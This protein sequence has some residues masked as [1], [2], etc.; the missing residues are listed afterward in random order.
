MERV[1]ITWSIG[2]T[3]GGDD[4]GYGAAAAQ[5]D[6]DYDF[7]IECDAALDPGAHD[8]ERV[9]LTPMRIAYDTGRPPEW[10]QWE[11]CW[12]DDDSTIYDM[13]ADAEIEIIGIMK[14]IAHPSEYGAD[15]M[16]SAFRQWADEKRALLK[17]EKDR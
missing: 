15:S 7:I 2:F 8:G 1:F 13:S 9:T 11:G 16:R 17:K 3:I 5:M 4:N 6:V 12:L 14:D 10:E